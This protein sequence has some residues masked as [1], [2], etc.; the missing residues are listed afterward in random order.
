[1]G[2]SKGYSKLH[3]LPHDS[4]LFM[5]KVTIK[6][7]PRTLLSTTY[8]AVCSRQKLVYSSN[9]QNSKKGLQEIDLRHPAHNFWKSCD[10]MN[11]GNS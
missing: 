1:M 4:S 2:Q 11:L 3:L 10:Y 6:L 8:E 5:L 9:I 7:T